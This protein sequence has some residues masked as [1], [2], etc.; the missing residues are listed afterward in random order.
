L[1]YSKTFQAVIGNEPVGN[2]DQFPFVVLGSRLVSANGSA[3][4]PFH[5]TSLPQQIYSVNQ[6]TDKWD[7]RLG[8]ASSIAI[9]IFTCLLALPAGAQAAKARLVGGPAI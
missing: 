9:V 7:G 1:P 6:M 4:I 3:R 2:F 8:I 5:K